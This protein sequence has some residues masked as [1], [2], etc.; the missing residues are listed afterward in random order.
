MREV[1]ITPPPWSFGSVFSISKN[2]R[3]SAVRQP[4]RS[5][6]THERLN[7]GEIERILE[8]L[9]ETHCGKNAF[10][11]AALQVVVVRMKAWSWYL[12]IAAMFVALTF[13]SCALN[14]EGVGPGAGETPDRNQAY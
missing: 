3:T 1:I 12:I 10:T 11:Q 13:S 14:Q 6:L 2:D 9:L 5:T 8:V 7:T 4:V